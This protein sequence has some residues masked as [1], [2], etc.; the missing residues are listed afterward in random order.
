MKRT[1]QTVRA[2]PG[3][4]TSGTMIRSGSLIP[5]EIFERDFSVMTTP[6]P[7]HALQPTPVGAGMSAVAGYVAGP[8]W[9]SLGR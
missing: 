1:V 6:W 2:A 5:F 4:A 3:F 9:L 7:N 8:A